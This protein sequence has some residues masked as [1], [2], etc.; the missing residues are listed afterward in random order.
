MGFYGGF[1]YGRVW[2]PDDAANSWHTS[3]GGGIFINGA[4]ILTARV[5]VFSGDE[6]A[7]F[8]FGIGFGF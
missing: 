7:R 3:Y 8:S 6:G 2:Y 1:D 5:A 4:D